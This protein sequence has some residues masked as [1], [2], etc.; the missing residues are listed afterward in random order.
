MSFVAPG[1]HPCLS[2]LP[3]PYPRHC[4]AIAALTVVTALPPIVQGKLIP[5]NATAMAASVRQQTSL[6][7]VFD[8]R[9]ASQLDTAAMRH[10]YTRLG[11]LMRT[12]EAR[13]ADAAGGGGGAPAAAIGWC[14]SLSNGLGRRLYLAVEAPAVSAAHPVLSVPP[15][16]PPL[17]P[18]PPPRPPA[19]QVT[20]MEEL[21]PLVQV[22]SFASLAATHT[23]G[24]M[25]ITEQSD[26]RTPFLID[27]IMQ[28]A[29][30]GASR[31]GGGAIGPAG[32]DGL[33]SLS[34]SR[35]LVNRVR[36]VRV[37][38]RRRVGLACG[39]ATRRDQPARATGARARTHT[40]ARL[41]LLRAR[42]PQT[43]R[44]PSSRCSS[45]SARW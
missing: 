17:L 31:A 39:L 9:H 3:T 2:A 38:S 42:R 21:S 15:P 35:L 25:V 43:R 36:A 45:A 6:E 41:P 19:S 13:G 37:S 26:Q 14:L 32:C 44:S 30:L 4:P 1:Q 12:L 11:S 40:P 16:P 22:A 8:A 10:C 27:P 20:N 24:F 7:F 28:L 23:Q 29:C 34:M 18:P 5:T 33:V